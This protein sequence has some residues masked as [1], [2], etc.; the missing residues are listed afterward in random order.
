MFFAINHLC[1]TLCNLIVTLC[2]F[3]YYTEGHRGGTEDHRVNK[4]ENLV[5]FCNFAGSNH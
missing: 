5:L 1:E 4:A 2:K 3:Y